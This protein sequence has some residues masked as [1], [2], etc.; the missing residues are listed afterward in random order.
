MTAGQLLGV[1]KQRL[2]KSQESFTPSNARD[3]AFD[4]VDEMDEVLALI[5]MHPDTEVIKED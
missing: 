5:N 2:E 4:A 1:I 3:W